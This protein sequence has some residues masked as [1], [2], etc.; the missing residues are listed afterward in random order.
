[1]NRLTAQRYI[2]LTKYLISQFRVTDSVM[3]SVFGVEDEKAAE[4]L[5]TDE[6]QNQIILSMQQCYSALG[7]EVFGLV[8]YGPDGPEHLIRVGTEESIHY[9]QALVDAYEE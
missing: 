4:K 3:I 5:R 1:V 6:L 8:V 7:V 2:D 9:A